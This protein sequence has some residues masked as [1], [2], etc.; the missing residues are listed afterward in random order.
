MAYQKLS[1]RQ[2][3]GVSATLKRHSIDTAKLLTTADPLPAL[4]RLLKRH[5]RKR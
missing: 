3:E 2:R 5:G 4:H 1:G